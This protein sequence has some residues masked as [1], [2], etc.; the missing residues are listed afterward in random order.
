MIS[1]SRIIFIIDQYN[2]SL[3]RKNRD[4]RI[5][6]SHDK[7][8]LSLAYCYE[9]L[10]YEIFI[11]TIEDISDDSLNS[12]QVLD[13]E[14]KLMREKKIFT[15]P[16][17]F[18]FIYDI[19]NV[20]YLENI[21]STKIALVA[22]CHW[23]ESPTLHPPIY[24]M[25]FI[26]SFTRKVDLIVANNNRMRFILDDLFRKLTNLKNFETEPLV[27]VLSSPTCAEKLFAQTPKDNK[28]NIFV[29]EVL[30]EWRSKKL[31]VCAGG[32]WN[33]TDYYNFLWEFIELVNERTDTDYRLLI[34]GF[35]PESLGNKIEHSSQIDRVKSMLLNNSAIVQGKYIRDLKFLNTTKSMDL[36]D[37]KILCVEDWQMGGRVLNEILPFASLGLS[38]NL[39][40]LESWQAFRQR[41]N[42]YISNNIPI[43]SSGVGMDASIENKKGLYLLMIMEPLIRTL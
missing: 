25:N 7:Y 40:T 32:I 28:S 13:F 37:K 20:S 3:I 6:Y 23:F 8:S 41:S 11:S 34:T 4:F 15:H 29:E 5:L 27:K 12:I 42:N 22:A 18:I 14:E 16:N 24:N 9:K 1:N 31:I 21:G 38:L 39:D 30:N 2:L 43:L 17:D 10:G 33:W 35:C 36:K 19:P 26:N